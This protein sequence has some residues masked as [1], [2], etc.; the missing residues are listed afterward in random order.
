MIPNG[1]GRLKDL[2]ER[3]AKSF[4]IESQ[5]ESQLSDAYDYFLPNRNLFNRDGVGQKK[6]DLIFDS[7][8][9]NAIQVGASKLQENLAPIWSRWS[10]FQLNESFE[11]RMAKAGKEIGDEQTILL[12][13]EAKVVFDYINRSNFHTQFFEMA[14]D[15]LIGTGTIIV[16]EEPGEEVFSFHAVPQISVGFEEG[17]SGRI[18]THWRKHNV[19]GRNI[20]RMWQGFKPSQEIANQINKQPEA[21]IKI[22]EGIIYDPTG[23]EYHGVAWCEDEDRESWYYN[24]GK[25]SPIITARYS[26]TAGEVRG[27]GP[28]LAVL[29]DVKTLNKVKEF[30]LM[31][32]AIDSA[33]IWT[34]TDDSVMNPYTITI[35][36]GVV[37]PVGSN[38]SSNPSLQRLNTSSDLNLTLFE[39]EELKN[40]IKT[41]LFNDLMAPD[42]PVKSATEIAIQHRE[43]VKRVGSAYGRLNTEGLVRILE[44]VI[45]LLV[46]RGKVSPVV[47]DREAVDV[48]FT[49]PLARAQDMEDILSVQQAVEFV[50][51]TGGAEAV[52]ASF[53]LD[54]FGKWVSGK[55]GMPQ[56]LLRSDQEKADLMEKTA[57]MMEASNK[58]SQAT[59]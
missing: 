18:E 32:A 1:L 41:A 12:Q 40:A 30:A 57:A 15:L 7:T 26:K 35:A 2:K 4:Q 28:A 31:K 24:Y 53:K 34:A 19:K 45:Y 27:R 43:L 25:H 48:K 21:K 55:T 9:I 5:W 47:M 22:T 33:G 59:A 50:M 58:N 42:S 20:E 38:N 56:E 52:M 8:A 54:E 10:I 3:A 37:I 46:K 36:P 51:A 29:P 17:P 14:L 6:M 39:I 23:G 49:S 13:N 44:R 11:E 16:Q